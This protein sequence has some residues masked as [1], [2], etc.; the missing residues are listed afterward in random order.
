VNR[1][2]ATPCAR[3]KR[4]HECVM[5]RS[6][7][8]SRGGGSVVPSR[9]FQLSKGAVY[10]LLLALPLL[11]LYE[12]GVAWSGRNGMTVINGA[13][14][15][16]KAPFI[17][18]F[19]RH[20]VVVLIA[21]LGAYAVWSWRQE[22]KSL[23]GRVEPRILLGMTL[24]SILYSFLLAPVIRILMTPL[25]PLGMPLRVGGLDSS[26]L[27]QLFLSLGAGVYEEL[28]FRVL[29]VGALMWLLE[30]GTKWSPGARTAAAVVAAALLFSLAHHVG[31]LGER[32]TTQAFMFRFVAGL[33]FTGL[34]VWRG[35][36]IA[37]ATHAFYDVIVT[38]R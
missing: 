2:R 35:F 14:A 21:L 25:A 27:Q 8:R 4:Y 11:V 1:R 10:S 23:G 38:L 17:Q 12:L 19:G 37:A 36:G 24:E 18:L 34:Y 7:T 28:V 15:L 22:G 30:R 9:Y 5:A 16:V 29:L 31:S 32:F 20:A 33:V 6:T 26:T 13:D 3:L